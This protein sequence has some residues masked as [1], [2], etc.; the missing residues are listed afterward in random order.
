MPI[1]LGFLPLRKHSEDF[2]YSE[3]LYVLFLCL[4]QSS[5]IL[6][7]MASAYHSGLSSHSPPWGGFPQPVQV[8]SAAYFLPA[9]HLSSLLTGL[10]NLTS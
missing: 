7:Q 1:T 9:V 5:Q 2:P 3:P 6:T 4:E 10:E 8:L